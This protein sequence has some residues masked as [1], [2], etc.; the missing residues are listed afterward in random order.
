MN[1]TK[2]A[3]T[4]DSDLLANLDRLVADQFF[5]NRSVAIQQAVQEKIER[6]EHTRL[7]RECAKLDPLEEQEIADEGL[8]EDFAEWPDY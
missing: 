3:I 7:A 5:P 4:I 2:V 1:K 6:L 8:V